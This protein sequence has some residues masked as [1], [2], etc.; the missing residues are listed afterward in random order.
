VQRNSSFQSHKSGVHSRD[1]VAFG[2]PLSLKR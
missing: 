2:D 1:A